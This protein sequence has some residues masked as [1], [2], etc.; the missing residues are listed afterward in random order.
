MAHAYD[1][2]CPV[3]HRRICSLRQHG[4][5]RSSWR[6]GD[7]P[8]R[9]LWRRGELPRPSSRSGRSLC[10][11]GSLREDVGSRQAPRESAIAESGRI[12]HSGH[13]SIAFSRWP[14]QPL[15]FV[16]RP[17]HGGQSRAGRER[18]CALPRAGRSAGGHHISRPRIAASASIVRDGESQR[19]PTTAQPGGPA[20]LVD[21]S[22][23]TRTD[24]R[25]STWLR[26]LYRIQGHDLIAR[27][28]VLWAPTRT[29][30]RSTIHSVE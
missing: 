26:G 28:R 9:A 21:L 27:G 8:R 1:R 12:S 23:D 24:D 16:Q 13:D 10:R 4:A 11:S 6:R 15:S 20:P 19:S 14:G 7:D 2:P 3:G 29:R 5:S 25:A 17:A 18:D 30:E 22:G